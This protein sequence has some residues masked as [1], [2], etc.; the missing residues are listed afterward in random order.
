MAGGG[1]GGGCGS[2]RTLEMR[3][4]ERSFISKCL[5]CHM[6][7]SRAACSGWRNACKPIKSDILAR[8]ATASGAW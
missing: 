6:H 3:A 5:R 1:G 7:S 4:D 8:R 2:D